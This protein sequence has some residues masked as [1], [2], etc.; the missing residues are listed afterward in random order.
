MTRFNL[1]S[2][3]IHLHFLFNT[4]TYKYCYRGSYSPNC[5]I[6]LSLRFAE[7]RVM[8]HSNLPMDCK[9]YK[10]NRVLETILPEGNYKVNV[11]YYCHYI[12]YSN[13]LSCPLMLLMSRDLLYVHIK[14]FKT[15]YLAFSCC[16]CHAIF[17]MYILKFSKHKAARRPSE[18]TQQL[19]SY[20]HGQN[21]TVVYLQRVENLISF[22][23]PT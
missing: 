12:W 9:E 15:N 16:S 4:G 1:V 18:N 22:T 23:N 6:D 19:D 3:F 14:I 5:P 13:K 7:Q 10:F 21:K 17:C 20:F 8:V 11:S 2:S